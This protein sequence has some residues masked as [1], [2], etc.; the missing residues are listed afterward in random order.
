MKELRI[1]VILHKQKNL[2]WPV[3]ETDSHCKDACN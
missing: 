1:Q 2:A 3:A